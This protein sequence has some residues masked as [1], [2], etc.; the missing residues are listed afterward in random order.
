[1]KL[2]ESNEFN[3]VEPITSVI[4]VPKLSE[5]EDNPEL[6]EVEDNPEQ[7]YEDTDKITDSMN[8]SISYED[9]N[10]ELV[11]TESITSDNG[12]LMKSEAFNDAER[13]LESLNFEPSKKDNVPI[14]ESVNTKSNINTEFPAVPKKTTIDMTS[15]EDTKIIHSDETEIPSPEMPLEIPSPEVPLEISSPEVPLEVP[16]P[17]VRLEVPSPEVRLEIPS[18]EVPLEV[19]VPPPKIPPEVPPEIH[20]ELITTVAPALNE[21]L[22]KTLKEYPIPDG[23]NREFIISQ[24]KLYTIVRKEIQLLGVREERFEPLK[25]PPEGSHLVHGYLIRLIISNGSIIAVEFLRSKDTSRKPESEASVTSEAP[26]G[27]AHTAKTR[28]E[29]LSAMQREVKEFHP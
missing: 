10:Q 8:Q 2:H 20:P 25:D 22:E 26:S 17:E 11:P 24:N 18:P 28:S 5:V 16:S 29:L 4:D 13:L 21:S 7:E 12:N 23:Y 3:N 1:M 19:E 15:H 27:E 14:P 6:S 9:T